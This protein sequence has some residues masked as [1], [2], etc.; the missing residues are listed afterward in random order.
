MVSVQPHGA[1]CNSA[2]Y[3]DYQQRLSLHLERV[4]HL[5]ARK[6][7][8]ELEAKNG[9]LQAIVTELLERNARLSVR[10]RELEGRS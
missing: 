3:A 7:N 9:R 6:R 8:R 4:H 2:R 5:Q 1:P 10:V